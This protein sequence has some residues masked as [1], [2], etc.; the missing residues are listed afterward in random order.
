M[1]LFKVLQAKF[2]LE[3]FFREIFGNWLWSSKAANGRSLPTFPLLQGGEFKATK[4]Q[5][6][7]LKLGQRLSE[8]TRRHGE[9]SLKS[10][11]GFK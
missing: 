7:S 1:D 2:E 8:K 10:L 11:F 4:L 3:A 5:R 9:C 6:N